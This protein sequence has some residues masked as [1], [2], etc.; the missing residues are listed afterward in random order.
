MPC[1]L[2][3]DFEEKLVHR[4]AARNVFR[5]PQRAPRLRPFLDESRLATSDALLFL[6]RPPLTPTMKITSLAFPA[7]ILSVDVKSLWL[8]ANPPMPARSEWRTR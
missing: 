5:G 6:P 3:P 7:A 4:S 1:A 2:R 8:V